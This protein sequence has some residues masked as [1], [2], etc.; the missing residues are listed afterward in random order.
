LFGNPMMIRSLEVAHVDDAKAA[1]SVA[2][3]ENDLHYMPIALPKP[4]S[5]SCAENPL[6]TE[7]A[8]APGA[9][10]GRLEAMYEGLEHLR[11]ETSRT[12]SKRPGP[13]V[14]LKAGARSGAAAARAGTAD[15]EKAI[16][17]WPSSDD[18]DDGRESSASTMTA[19][20]QASQILESDPKLVIERKQH[21][22]PVGASVE[23]RKS[24]KQRDTQGLN[25]VWHSM[26]KPEIRKARFAFLGIGLARRPEILQ[27][28]G[29]SCLLY[30][31]RPVHTWAQVP[32]ENSLKSLYPCFLASLA[33]SKLCM[34]NSYSR[35]PIQVIRPPHPEP[36]SP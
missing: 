7:P 31:P 20:R 23:R 27:L 13:A 11:L 15:G 24:L 5:A 6:F 12:P 25:K 9:L 32:M 4:Q 35:L 28:L 14:H 22:T 33:K 19:I 1:K 36:H 8:A 3:N 16:F 26:L 21:Q 18:E 17:F 30:G 10:Q 34:A 29:R 2:G